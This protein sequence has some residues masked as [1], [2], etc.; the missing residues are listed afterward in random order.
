MR[1][2]GTELVEFSET[3]RRHDLAEY[4][5]EFGGRRS[6]DELCDLRRKVRPRRRNVVASAEQSRDAGVEVGWTEAYH[7]G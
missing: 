3:S 2:T 1:G 7:R 6:G 5:V 4:P